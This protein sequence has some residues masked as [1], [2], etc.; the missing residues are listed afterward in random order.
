MRITAH[1]G[2]EMQVQMTGPLTKA[3]AYTRSQPDTRC[4]SLEACC[5]KSPLPC[6]LR[7]KLHRA[8]AVSACIRDTNPSGEQGR[9]D[10]EATNDHCARFMGLGGSSS[11]WSARSHRP[12][13]RK[14]HHQRKSQ[15]FI[16]SVRVPRKEA[17]VSRC[18]L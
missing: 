16:H 13:H 7:D 15:I 17:V 10:A 1:T 2:N 3:I 11:R 9:D 18:S 12:H 8:A 4:T 6:F 5:T 14:K